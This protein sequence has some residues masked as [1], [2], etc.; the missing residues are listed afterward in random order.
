MAVQSIV[1]SRYGYFK[2]EASE[3]QRTLGLVSDV[4]TLLIEIQRTWSYLEPLFIG[5]E[6]VR[7]ELPDDAKRFQEIDKEVKVILQKAWKIRNVKD[8]CCQPNLLDK[9]GDLEKKQDQC[10]K[11]LS[12]FLDG[13]RRQFPRFYFMSEAD[14]LDLLSNSSQP[15]KVLE[16]VDKILLATRALTT[17]ITTGSDRP[18]ATHFIA[19]VGKEV[20]QF[21]PAVRLIGK[22][23]QYL[24]SL[25]NAQIYTL[26]K[27]L[28]ASMAKYPTQLRVEWVTS[29]NKKTGDA[30]D[31]AQ[32]ILLVAAVDFVMQVEKSMSQSSVGDPKSILKC[33]ELVKSQLADL[34]NLTQA[35]LSKSD[36]Q[37][38][39][40]MITLDAHSRDIIDNLI[41]EK[42]YAPT[43]FQ[44]QSKLRPSFVGDVGKSV[45]H[46]VSNAK[47]NICD[48]S[49]DYGFEY[50]GNG[51]RLVVTPLTDRIYVTATQALHLKMGCAPA[52]KR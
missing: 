12:D 7:K 42:A 45:T 6:E 29:K 8:T 27:C 36:R 31:P 40:C 11:S 30:V 38:V 19:G 52:G 16:Q 35:P 39:M 17:E 48:A 33:Y 23:E 20:V 41:K 13:K 26:S 18:Q 44:W 9:L 1:G 37:R 51:P 21:E 34:I 15:N 25:L 4:S 3:W 2:K 28:A 43:D 24:L 32:V 14:L 22:A 5:S 49:F 50:L 10:K 46:I 47:F